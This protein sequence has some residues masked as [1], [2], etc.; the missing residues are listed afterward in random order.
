MA[1]RR[2]T[3]PTAAPTLFEDR[4]R[5]VVLG[6]LASGLAF[7]MVSVLI[8]PSGAAYWLALG[9][10]PLAGALAGLM[11]GGVRGRAIDAW[12]LGASTA[13]PGGAPPPP[14]PSAL[15]A[16]ARAAL[17]AALVPVLLDELGGRVDAMEPRCAAAART[18]AVTAHKALPDML[19]Q[20]LPGLT[21]GLLSGSTAAA[22][23][24]EALARRMAG[25]AA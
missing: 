1:P 7:V 14:A 17:Q 5:R 4:Q 19:V 9:V 3:A 10:A 12:L 22:A 25:G 16:P 11:L 2:Q 24:A 21:A 6:L 23:E 15:P 18:L 20:A 13:G 8:T